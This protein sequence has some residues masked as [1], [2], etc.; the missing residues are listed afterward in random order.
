[1]D[2]GEFPGGEEAKKDAWIKALRY[3]QVRPRSIFEMQEFLGRKG[4]AAGTCR[5]VIDRLAETKYLDDRIFARALIETR[6]KRKSHSRLRIRHALEE[7]GIEDEIIEGE[8]DDAFGSLCEFDMARAD[9]NEFL[10]KN[11]KSDRDTI[12]RRLW[13]RL[14]RKGYPTALVRRVLEDLGVMEP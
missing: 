7:Y 10:R 1:M 4:F 13:G 5:D 12:K 9:A 2:K 14:E 6:I 8:L 11:A 3:L